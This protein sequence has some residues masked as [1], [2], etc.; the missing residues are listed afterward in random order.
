MESIFGEKYCNEYFAKHS[1]KVS[2][3]FSIAMTDDMTDT[4]GSWKTLK[5]I[6]QYH[7]FRSVRG[8]EG[9]FL[10]DLI[11]ARR[12]SCLCDQCMS[13]NFENCQNKDIYGNWEYVWLIRQKYDCCDRPSS[14]D[15]V[16]SDQKT[17][18]KWYHFDCT[19]VDPATVHQN[20]WFC[21]NCAKNH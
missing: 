14:N 1:Q 6:N 19:G 2:R 3:Y 16:R 11:A 8:T 5:N 9:Y 4:L 12:Y 7:C 10:K 13:N 17:C 18:Q 20:A 21:P 15:M